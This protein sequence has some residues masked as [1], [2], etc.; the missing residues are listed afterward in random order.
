[1]AKI[2]T[3]GFKS[4]HTHSE[5]LIC[6]VNFC[7]VVSISIQCVSAQQPFALKFHLCYRQHLLVRSPT[8]HLQ[9]AS[10]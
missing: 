1:M 3:V 7:H 4:L 6:L 10:S 2:L 5:P 8:V 9:I